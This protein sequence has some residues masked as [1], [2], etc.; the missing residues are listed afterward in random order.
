MVNCGCVALKGLFGGAPLRGVSLRYTP[1][2]WYVALRALLL[3]IKIKRLE[4]MPAKFISYMH[5]N[6]QPGW[7]SI[8]GQL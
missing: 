1:S 2:L 6:L 7:T 3:I 5:P 4:F 8:S